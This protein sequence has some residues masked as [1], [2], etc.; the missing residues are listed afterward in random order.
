MPRPIR[1][2]RFSTQRCKFARTEGIIL[3]YLSGH[4]HFDLGSYE[5]YLSGK[6]QDYEYPGREIPVAMAVV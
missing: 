2:S 5:N 3:F 1:R 6:L 4:G